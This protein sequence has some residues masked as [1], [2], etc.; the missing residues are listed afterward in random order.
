MSLSETDDPIEMIRQS[1]ADPQVLGRIWEHYRDR[2][3]RYGAKVMPSCIAKPAKK[4]AYGNSCR[5][6]VS[7]SEA[8]AGN[9]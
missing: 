9:D 8:V 7:K 2:L 3:V 1:G 6:W 5:I 4:P